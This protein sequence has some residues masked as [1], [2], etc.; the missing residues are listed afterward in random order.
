MIRRPPRSTLFP[1]TTLFRSLGAEARDALGRRKASQ[2]AIEA[3]GPCRAI[4]CRRGNGAVP[5]QDPGGTRHPALEFP[6]P[7]ARGRGGGGDRGRER[8]RRSGL[9]PAVQR[10]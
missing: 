3:G 6:S 9:C 4:A 10:L 5:C 7:A 2:F 8:A 1:Y